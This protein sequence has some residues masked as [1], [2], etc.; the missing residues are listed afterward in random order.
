[1]NVLMT[2]GQ[3]LTWYSDPSIV[4]GGWISCGSTSAAA[5]P[6]TPPPPSPVPPT[7]AGHMFAV[8]SGQQYC[9]PVAAAGLPASQCI[10]D[11]IGNHGNAE[12]CT[13]RV[14]QNVYVTSVYFETE[15][16]YDFITIGGTQYSGT[17]SE[18][19]SLPS[20]VVMAAGETMIHRN[21][22]GAPAWL[23]SPLSPCK[24]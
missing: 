2:A 4:R 17:G 19:F 7:L 15:A 18:Y 6:P 8:V 20:D 5:V 9:Q 12:R 22:T 10:T 21:F 23:T 16:N 13:I 3:T 1:M 14:T 11:G 24:K